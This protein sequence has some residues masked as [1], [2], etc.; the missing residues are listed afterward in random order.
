MTETVWQRTSKYESNVQSP[1]QT[2]IS[3]LATHLKLQNAPRITLPAALPTC[4][5]NK[6]LGKN[7][8]RGEPPPPPTKKMKGGKTTGN[9]KNTKRYGQ[10]TRENIC[11]TRS[12]SKNEQHTW[13]SERQRSLQPNRGKT[14]KNEIIQNEQLATVVPKFK[15]QVADSSEI[16]LTTMETC[17][18][19]KLKF[20]SLNVADNILCMLPFKCMPPSQ[21]F[22]ARAPCLM[23]MGMER[24][25]TILTI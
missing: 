1:P 9:Q 4:S 3:Q 11:K 8:G 24:T 15:P 22:Q 18:L 6:D 14:K 20:S 2:T 16:K 7:A 25:G 17:I 23:G 21:G 13:T 5:W 12:P 10:G 19:D